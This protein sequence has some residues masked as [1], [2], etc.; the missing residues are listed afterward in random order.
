MSR[1]LWPL[2]VDLL[3]ALLADPKADFLAGNGLRDGADAG[4]LAARRADEHH[5][6][7]RQRCRQVDDA[8]WDNGAADTRLVLDR[9]RTAVLLDDVDVLDDHLAVFRQRLDHAAF[10]AGVLAAEDVDAVALLDLHRL[11]HG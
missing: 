1:W 6:R 2:L 9:A 3:A 8:A 7:D 10:L 4:R 5:V 11:S